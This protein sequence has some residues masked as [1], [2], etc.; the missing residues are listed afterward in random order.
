MDN[1]YPLLLDRGDK[2]TQKKV[3]E[4]RKQTEERSNKARKSAKARRNKPQTYKP[5]VYN[6]PKVVKEGPIPTLSAAQR[7]RK[8]LNDGYE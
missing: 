2:V 1:I 6:K 7:A 8:M 5:K 3:L 4:V